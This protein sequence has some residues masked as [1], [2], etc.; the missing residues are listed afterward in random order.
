M[1]L[2]NHSIRLCYKIGYIATELVCVCIKVLTQSV[3][4]DI[5]FHYNFNYIDF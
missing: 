5:T 2:P 3:V 4:Y 1:I